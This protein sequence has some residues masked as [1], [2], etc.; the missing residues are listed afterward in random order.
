LGFVLASLGNK[1]PALL[2]WCWTPPESIVKLLQWDF[3]NLY[4]YK[5]L[6]PCGKN[7][8]LD[9]RY[10]I[11]FHTN[12]KT[13]LVNGLWRFVNSDEET[14]YR[15]LTAERNLVTGQVTTFKKRFGTPKTLWVIVRND[16]PG[17]Q[18]TITCQIEDILSL[19][20]VRSGE[21]P[22]IL[23]EVM[24]DEDKS[25][26]DSCI[27]KMSISFYRGYIR[28]FAP[29]HRANDVDLDSWAILLKQ[30][31]IITNRLPDKMLSGRNDDRGEQN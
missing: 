13:E 22:F 25:T 30:A 23:L 24:A 17:S 20:K 8:I 21:T 29:H 28:R 31:L 7:Q 5:A 18:P 10:G 26:V 19:I 14:R 2:K 12:V 15:I 1:S 11:R 4:E 6:V 16:Y 27:E 9:Q 3:A